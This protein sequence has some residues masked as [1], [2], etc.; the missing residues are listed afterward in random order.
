M[1]IKLPLAA[2]LAS[3][4]TCLS[5]GQTVDTPIN[6]LEVVSRH[7]P[8]LEAIDTSAPLTVGNGSFAFTVDI[9]GLQ[10]FGQN[11]HA[12]GIPLE[13]LARWC[14][15][16]EKNPEGYTLQNASRDFTQADGSIIS[17]PARGTSVAAGRWL[18]RNPRLHPLGQLSLEWLDAPGGKLTEAMIESPSQTLDLWRGTI[19]S[20][21]QLGGEPVEVVTS[22]DS[23][24]DSVAL[25]IKSPLI[26]SGKIRVRIDFPR[27]HDIAT[28]NTPALD[29]TNSEHHQSL[30]LDERTVKRNVLDASYY[31][32]SS[33]PLQKVDTHSFMIEGSE[34]QTLSFTFRFSPDNVLAPTY[35]AAKKRGQE[36][37]IDF[38]QT[39][40]AADFSGS[41]N[42]IAEKLENRMV[43][44]RY[45]TAAQCVSTFPPQESGLTCNTWYGKHHTEMVWWHVAHFIAWG[46]SNYAEEN[47]SWFLDR[48]PVAQK[49][50]S[51][52]GL[53]GARWSKMVGPDGRESPGGNPL[54]VWNQPHPI[55]LAELLRRS[56]EEPE[57]LE[58]YGDL[59]LQSAACMASMLHFDENRSEYVLGPPLWIAQEIHDQSTSQNPSFELAYWNWAL[60]I[61]QTWRGKLGMERVEKWD[62]IL[63]H[64]PELPQSQGKYVALESYPDTWDNIDSRHDHPQML[65]PLGFLPETDYVDRSI[66]NA[67]LDGVLAE[68]DWEAKIWGWDYP[69]VAMTAARLGRPAEAVEI[70]LRDGPNNRYTPNGHCPQGSDEVRASQSKGHP[71]IAVYLPANGSFLSALALM[72]AGWDGSEN[73][74][75]GFPDDGSWQIKTEGFAPLP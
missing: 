10:T 64:L 13:T 73:E 4:F 31:A 24:S 49:L 53:D 5:L 11:Y 55:Y 63:A 51:E 34:E 27:G 67:T 25:Q 56:G 20:T 9:T 17:L 62:H 72:L 43:L 65:M 44:S 66:M 75:P 69:I 50:A 37:W 46:K 70:L 42:P 35:E 14:W 2:A 19:T 41:T 68:W 8:H 58:T 18:R 61:A 6:R 38:W 22:C 12:T 45:L 23:D 26:E 71:E 57:I 47:L 28:K 40:A 33:N 29:W 48:L 36:H 16:S 32:I 21:Y 3:L 1:I 52:R 39:G 30:Q 59:V 7:N 15:T 74:F 60:G 54:I